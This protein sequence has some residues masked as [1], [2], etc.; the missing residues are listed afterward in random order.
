MVQE[1]LLEALVGEK[2]NYKNY[3]L[4]YNSDS[5]IAGAD[6]N[7]NLQCLPITGT[8]T[9]HLGNITYTVELNETSY[10]ITHF[11]TANVETGIGDVLSRVGSSVHVFAAYNSY[12]FNINPPKI[13]DIE[14]IEDISV[15][16]DIQWGTDV[17]DTDGSPYEYKESDVR[18]A[19]LTVEQMTL[20]KQ[21]F[22]SN[23]T[24]PTALQQVID[25][26]NTLDSV[27]DAVNKVLNEGLVL[28]IVAYVYNVDSI[29]IENKPDGTTEK[30]INFN[31]HINT[32]AT[33][34]IRVEKSGFLIPP[35]TVSTPNLLDVLNNIE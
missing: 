22:D 23:S 31:E 2:S 20:L 10:T 34:C 11:N 14:D 29:T 18:Y 33:N 4:T 32:V 15:Q 3:V 21:C 12:K 35:V 27:E 9:D 30:V 17:F 13:D 16:V 19:A 7:N 24:L 25:V 5:F 1:D 8:T 6:P 28:Y 26:G